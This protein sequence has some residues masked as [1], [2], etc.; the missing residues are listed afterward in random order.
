LQ[1]R[2]DAPEVSLYNPHFRHCFRV[3]PSSEFR[4]S[5]SMLMAENLK[6]KNESVLK[7]KSMQHLSNNNNM[8][9]IL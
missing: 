8:N 2:H 6:N 7:K 5:D 3:A 1:R 4:C 9:L